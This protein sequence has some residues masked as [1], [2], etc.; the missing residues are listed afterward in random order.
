MTALRLK[1][2]QG[3]HVST[4]IPLGLAVILTVAVLVF[5]FAAAWGNF[6]N[7]IEAAGSSDVFKTFA[8]QTIDGGQLTAADLRGH[9][10]VAVN[11]WGTDCPPCLAEL[12]DFERLS[13]EYSPEDFYVIGFPMDVTTHGEKIVE[14]RLAEANR[15]CEA[16]GIDFP[17]LIADPAMD[18]F[19]RSIIVGTP[20]TLY[21][22][23]DGNII[24]T[25]T[26]ARAYAVLKETVDSLLKER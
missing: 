15:I 5:S 1:N 16:A 12:P 21:L 25:V 17:N 3:M 2:R 10:L 18:S 23:A 20:T 11:I 26:G 6:I 19:I 4:L 8:L 9:K 22:D 7:G 13:K 14:K 24:H